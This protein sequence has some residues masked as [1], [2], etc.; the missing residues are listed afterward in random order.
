MEWFGKYNNAKLLILIC[1]VYTIFMR[2]SCNAFIANSSN[3]RL[4]GLYILLSLYPYYLRS[5]MANML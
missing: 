2:I 1:K 5:V 3:G 4:T